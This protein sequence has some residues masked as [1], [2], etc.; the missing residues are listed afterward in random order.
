[1]HH[2]PALSLPSHFPPGYVACRECHCSL[3]NLPNTGPTCRSCG[4]IAQLD[5]QSGHFKIA[6][7]HG[8]RRPGAGRKPGSPT[9][10][11]REVIDKAADAGITPLELQPATMR[12]I[13]RRA[14]AHGDIDEGLA[15]QACQIARDCAPY[16]HPRLASVEAKI[17]AANRLEIAVDV[18]RREGSARLGIRR[19]PTA[20]TTQCVKATEKAEPALGGGAVDGG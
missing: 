8:G 10:R 13:W 3:A 1:M 6:N 12:E 5:L 17:D 2:R 7:G 15:T 9:K 18:V 16:I 4:G 14:H 11:C 20:A 19:A